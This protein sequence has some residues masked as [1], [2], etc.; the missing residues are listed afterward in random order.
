[1]KIYDTICVGTKSWSCLHRCTLYIYNISN[2]VTTIFI[3]YNHVHDV[4]MCYTSQC[5]VSWP[6]PW[7]LNHTYNKSSSKY[8]IENI[9]IDGNISIL[10]KKHDYCQIALVFVQMRSCW[11]KLEFFVQFNI[12][13][14]E[15]YTK[16]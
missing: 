5:S 1:M 10:Y 12:L 4:P 2:K 7:F 16:I 8:G 13:L 15:I 11:L 9:Y 6:Y 14:I 3:A